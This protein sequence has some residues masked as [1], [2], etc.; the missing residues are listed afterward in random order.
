MQKLVTEQPQQAVETYKEASFE[1]I[2]PEWSDILSQNGGF[3]KNQNA[4][5]KTED[6]KSRSIMS[7]PSCL[8]GELHANS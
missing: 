3:V 5:F 4:K 8:V 7:A 1:E 2:C 6:G